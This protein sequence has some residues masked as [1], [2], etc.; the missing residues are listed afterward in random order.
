MNLKNYL[1]LTPGPSPERKREKMHF[2]SGEGRNTFGSAPPLLMTHP[3]R[4]PAHFA[5]RSRRSVLRRGGRGVR[6]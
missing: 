1:G 2:R 4:S 6:L 3:E 5:G